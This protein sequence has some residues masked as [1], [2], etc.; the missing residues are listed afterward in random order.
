[1]LARSTSPV[2]EKS[3]AELV[4]AR[5]VGRTERPLFQDARLRHRRSAR[6]DH[7]QDR[8]RRRSRATPQALERPQLP[9]R[10]H[11][12]DELSTTSAAP[13]RGWWPICKNGSRRTALPGRPK[14]VIAHDTRHF[15]REFAELTAQGRGG[16]RLRRRVSSTGRAR[17]RSFPSPCAI[18]TPTAGI[19]ITASHNPPH[20]NG[21]KVYF[22][23][24]AQ[25]V[26]PHASG[27]IAKVNAVESRRLRAA[28]R[29]R[30][31]QAHHA[32]QGDRRRLHGAAG[33]AHARSRDGRCGGAERAED[34]LHRA[35]TA[36]AASSPSRCS[37]G[38]ASVR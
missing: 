7:R 21:Y 27:I 5:R 32:R 29:R 30:A 2:V 4:A 19:V 13:R 14:I 34:R 10:R 11:E 16:T 25:V 26:E 37:S 1:M 9:V 6:T 8:D 35:S 18:S 15:S 3:I 23:D 33:D 38:S 12:R 17:R 28:C 22:A 36:P 24:G 31:R 20:D